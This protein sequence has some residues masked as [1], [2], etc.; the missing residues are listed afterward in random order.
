MVVEVEISSRSDPETVFYVEITENDTC[1]DAIN[2][3]GLAPR[4]GTFCHALDGNGKIIDNYLAC[5]FK[6]IFV[7]PFPTIRNIVCH[8]KKKY[9]VKIGVSECEDYSIFVPSLKVG[10]FATVVISDTWNSAD[11]I[12]CWAYKVELLGEPYHVGDLV[13]MIPR[14]D[15]GEPKQQLYNPITGKFDLNFQLDW[16][17]HKPIFFKNV[18]C[19]LKVT[20]VKPL[21]CEFVKE[22]TFISRNR[23]KI[24]K[25]RKAIS[26]R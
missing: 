15:D 26:A 12:R 24:N 8:K 22:T 16:K 9:G 5:T 7:V 21:M 3:S 23:N 4:D 19:I 1:L 6:K 17:R 20:S 10:D 14:N 11:N 2:K 25:N 18:C 13:C